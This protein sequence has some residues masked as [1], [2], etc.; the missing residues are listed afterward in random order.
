MNI[1]TYDSPLRTTADGLFAAKNFE[2]ALE[3]YL[4]SA[5]SNEANLVYTYI[6]GAYAAI[7]LG[8]FEILTKFIFAAIDCKKQDTVYFYKKI[9]EIIF[10]ALQFNINID[11]NRV[12]EM[13]GATQFYISESTNFVFILGFPRCGTTSISSTLITSGKYIESICQEP[14]TISLEIT[15]FNSSIDLWKKSIWQFP[16]MNG[17]IVV[18][19]STHH[20]LCKHYYENLFFYFPHAE[21]I[22]AVRDPLGRALS[23]YRFNVM[24][25][26]TLHFDAAIELEKSLIQSLG[27]VYAIFDSQNLFLSFLNKL[28]SAG[29]YLP[30]IYPS[31]VMANI[32]SL[33]D[34]IYVDQLTFIDVRT[35]NIFGREPSL[36]SSNLLSGLSKVLN[37]SSSIDI[38]IPEYF[39][40]EY[41]ITFPLNQNKREELF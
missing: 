36:I 3:K 39:T 23:A 32:N 11:I 4:E 16:G 27:G 10:R 21:F 19:K 34:K 24:Q 33:I 26:S 8:K 28:A 29:I 25:G 7:S 9:G 15:D 22:V 37:P 1:N 30:I 2:M 12:R 14:L 38:D 31:V 18:E 5:A 35:N 40:D 13:L 6:N 41:F 20:L 17:D